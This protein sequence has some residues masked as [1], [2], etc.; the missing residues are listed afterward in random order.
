[1]KYFEVFTVC[2]MPTQQPSDNIWAAK[3]IMNCTYNYTYLI[4]IHK[5]KFYRKTYIDY[6]LI[7]NRVKISFA[8]KLHTI[9]KSMPFC[10]W[11]RSTAGRTF[12]TWQPEIHVSSSHMVKW[13]STC[14]IHVVHVYTQRHKIFTKETNIVYTKKSFNKIHHLSMRLWIKGTN[15]NKKEAHWHHLLKG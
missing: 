6:I 13:D 2:C 15:L 5:N 7:G 11:L 12:V 3:I 14:S 10:S 8:K 1:M 9:F 4:N